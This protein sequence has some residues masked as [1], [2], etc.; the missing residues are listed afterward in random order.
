M[1]AHTLVCVCVCLCKGVRESKGRSK[2][3]G[4]QIIDVDLSGIRVPGND[5]VI[6]IIAFE[7]FHG[8]DTCEKGFD[9]RCVVCFHP[10]ATYAHWCGHGG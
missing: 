7:G 8:E 1:H 3:E 4:A 10:T 6:V 5:N 9:G 2:K